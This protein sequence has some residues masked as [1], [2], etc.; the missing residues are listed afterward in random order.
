MPRLVLSRPPFVV[1][2]ID[3]SQGLL[4]LVPLSRTT[5]LE[6]ESSG[7]TVR[8][9]WRR[10]RRGVTARLC[11]GDREEADT[12]VGSVVRLLSAPYKARLSVPPAPNVVLAQ[13]VGEDT[14]TGV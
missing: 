4:P 10:Y 2:Q 14:R 1:S 13:G 7:I 5:C 9:K 11:G 8:V 3:S 12:A 6:S